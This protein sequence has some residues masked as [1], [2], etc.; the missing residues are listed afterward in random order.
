MF[1]MYAYCNV[2]STG[3]KYYIIYR[4]L[5]IL[6]KIENMYKY[7]QI[8]FIAVILYFNNFII[9]TMMGKIAKEKNIKTYSFICILYF[10]G[11]CCNTFNQYCKSNFLNVSVA[12]SCIY[13]HVCAH[14]LRVHTSHTHD[15]ATDPPGGCRRVPLR[16]PLANV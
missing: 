1:N 9:L 4:K 12:W 8:Y 5:V 16:V 11:G 7:Y 6:M 3:K 14:I 2:S 15:S 13:A 10:L